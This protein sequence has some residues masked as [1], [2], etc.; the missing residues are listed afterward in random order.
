MLL[1]KIKDIKNGRIISGQRE[2]VLDSEKFLTYKGVDI[3]KDVDSHIGQTRYYYI[4][5]AGDKIQYLTL[6]EIEKRID[7]NLSKDSKTKDAGTSSFGTKSMTIEELKKKAKEGQFEYWSDPKPRQHI[8]IRYPN[9][10][11]EQVWVE[12]SKTKDDSRSEEAYDEGHEAALMGKSSSANPYTNVSRSGYADLKDSWNDGFNDGQKE[13]AKRFRESKDS[14][15]KDVWIDDYRDYKISVREY[16]KDVFEFTIQKNG[17][18]IYKGVQ[19]TLLGARTT[20]R[21][22]I[23]QNKVKDSKT[24]DDEYNKSED[25]QI[26]FIQATAKNVYGKDITY[27]K[28]KE[29]YYDAKAQGRDIYEALK[30]SFK[31]ML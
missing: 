7:N 8:E 9:G 31:T 25:T 23:D 16:G 18:E 13:V 28:A 1:H 2:L 29:I 19:E 20:A 6:E 15:T 30:F 10:K 3:F 21:R 12:D 11:T 4:G 14:K 5:S 24:K 27:E 22:L 26:R 17:R